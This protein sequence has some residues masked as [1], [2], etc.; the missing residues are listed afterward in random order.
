MIAHLKEKPAPAEITEAIVRRFWRAVEMGDDSECW[1]WKSHRDRYG[2]GQFSIGN[3]PYRA[4]RVAYWLWNARW[5]DPSVKL[6]HSCDARGC[7]NPYHLTPGTQADN[8]RDRMRRE[9]YRTMRRGEKHGLAKLTEANVR[10]IRGVED[11]KGVNRDLA[12]RFGVSEGQIS[13]I[14]RRH[15]WQWLQQEDHTP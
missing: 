7:C 14:R 8:M 12:G 15:V 2:Y 5:F 9:G 13:R 10:V 6:R 4:H 1:L 11:Y 3:H